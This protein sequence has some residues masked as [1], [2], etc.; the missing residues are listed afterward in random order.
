MTTG[1]NNILFGS[2]VDNSLQNLTFQTL[3]LYFPRKFGQQNQTNTIELSNL[4]LSNAVF[5][6]NF[7]ISSQ[8]F[9]NDP[10]CQI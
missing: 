3:C 5:K 10:F 7:K 9:C 4:S 2:R 6:T 8:E 1:N